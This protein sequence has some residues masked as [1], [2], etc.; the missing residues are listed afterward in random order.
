MY[1]VTKQQNLLKKQL[2]NKKDN[3]EMSAGSGEE[4]CDRCGCVYSQ[5]VGYLE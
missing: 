2:M 3:K 5:L 1:G 4:L